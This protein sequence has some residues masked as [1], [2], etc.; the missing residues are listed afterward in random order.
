MLTGSPKTHPNSLILISSLGKFPSRR[1]RFFLFSFGNPSSSSYHFLF[2]FYCFDIAQVAR[3]RMNT[4]YNPSGPSIVYC[5]I[6]HRIDSKQIILK[7]T[8]EKIEK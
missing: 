1:K 3:I 8:I 6:D 2:V 4:R 7:P 5:A